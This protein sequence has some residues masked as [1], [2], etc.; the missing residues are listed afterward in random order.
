MSGPLCSFWGVKESSIH[1]KLS[2]YFL[3]SVISRPLH[4]LAVFNIDVGMHREGDAGLS[5]NFSFQVH[6]ISLLH[7][8]DLIFKLKI[9]H[10]ILVNVMI[11]TVIALIL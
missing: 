5:L 4:V 6:S 7:S 3:F 10:R 8:D 9:E 2:G 11:C 1:F